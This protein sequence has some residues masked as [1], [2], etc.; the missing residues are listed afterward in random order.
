MSFEVR[1]DKQI[2]LPEGEKMIKQ[3]VQLD[4]IYKLVKLLIL[5]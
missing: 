1:K 5:I 3:L 4:K 2:K